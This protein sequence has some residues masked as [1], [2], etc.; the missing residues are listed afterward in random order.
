MTGLML[1]PVTTDDRDDQSGEKERCVVKLMQVRGLEDDCAVRRFFGTGRMAGQ[2][3]Q[4]S[5]GQPDDDLHDFL[6]SKSK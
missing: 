6:G 1:F 4:L 2:Y 3:C 5:N